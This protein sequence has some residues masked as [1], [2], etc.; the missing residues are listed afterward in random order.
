VGK[1]LYEFISSIAF[2]LG[3]RECVS[4]GLILVDDLEK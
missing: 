4:V 3:R 2:F 1:G